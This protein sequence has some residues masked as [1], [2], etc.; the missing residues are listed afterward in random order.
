MFGMLMALAMGISS[1]ATVT[2]L[3]AMLQALRNKL[4]RRINH[5]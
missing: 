4:P 1:I 5:G 3:P 2:V